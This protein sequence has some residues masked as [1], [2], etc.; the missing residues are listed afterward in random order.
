MVDRE[1]GV[2]SDDGGSAWSKPSRTFLRHNLT[3]TEHDMLHVSEQAIRFRGL[4][5]PPFAHRYT[6]GVTLAN[7]DDR[8]KMWIDNSL[9]LD[10]WASLSS[11]HLTGTLAIDSLT[12]LYALEL[13]YKDGNTSHSKD[14]PSSGPALTWTCTCPTLC[15]AFFVSNAAVAS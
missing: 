6:F 5:E 13:E 15:S 8:V 3:G 11:Q 7:H 12:P 4:I 10:E 14:S 9:V 2:A 1:S